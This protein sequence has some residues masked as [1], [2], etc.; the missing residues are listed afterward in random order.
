MAKGTISIR[1]RI[2]DTIGRLAL[3]RHGKLGVI[4]SI[5][6]GEGGRPVF[7]GWRFLMP[8]M[9]WQSY[10]PILL[11]SAE[12]RLIRAMSKGISEGMMNLSDEMRAELRKAVRD[13][14]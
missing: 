1:V 12:E 4:K 2:E 11:V 10:D 8:C 6:E 13:F 9:S 7:K 3:C 14:E 5:E